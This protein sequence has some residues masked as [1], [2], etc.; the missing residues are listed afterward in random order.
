MGVTQQVFR[1]LGCLENG[2]AAE[3]HP[4]RRRSELSADAAK[5]RSLAAAIR[6][7]KGEPLPARNAEIDVAQHASRAVPNGNVSHHENRIGHARAFLKC[8]ADTSSAPGRAA[9]SLT[10]SSNAKALTD[11]I[12]LRRQAAERCACVMVMLEVTVT[13]ASHHSAARMARSGLHPSAVRNTAAMTVH[14]SCLSAG[15]RA[16]AHA[17]RVSDTG[18]GRSQAAPLPAI[19]TRAVKRTPRY[20]AIIQTVRRAMATF[21]DTSMG[22]ASIAGR[23]MRATKRGWSHTRACEVTQCDKL[24]RPA[25]LADERRLVCDTGGRE[26]GFSGCGMN[27]P[28]KPPT[29][30]A[31][32]MPARTTCPARSDPGA[33]FPAIALARL[34]TSTMMPG[35]RH[36]R[37]ATIREISPRR[38]GSA[39]SQLLR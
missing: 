2:V 20:T 3:L 10:R 8:H 16:T 9:C 23:R 1:F 27:Q 7:H 36:E 14:W 15:V 35:T 19:V 24:A 28:S 13:S 38:S 29:R 4:P 39:D 5:E 21:A 32:A 25:S 11:A 18:V 17:K 22:N 31:I 37:S 33:S 30:P 34:R 26:A 12:S 6:A